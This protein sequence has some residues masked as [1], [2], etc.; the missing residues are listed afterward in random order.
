MK[1]A[2]PAGDHQDLPRQDT[3]HYRTKHSFHHRQLTLNGAK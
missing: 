2:L 1:W 3:Y